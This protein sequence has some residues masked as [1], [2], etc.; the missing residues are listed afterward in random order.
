MEWN[1]DRTTFRGMIWYVLLIVYFT[2]TYYDILNSK[3][4]LPF[5]FKTLEYHMVCGMFLRHVR[6]KVSGDW[7]LS[8]CKAKVFLS[9]L[10]NMHP[11]VIFQNTLNEEGGIKVEDASIFTMRYTD[12]TVLIAENVSSQQNILVWIKE[13]NLGNMDWKWIILHKKEVCRSCHKRPDDRGRRN[14]NGKNQ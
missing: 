6:H 10:F 4:L 9:L 3:S 11:A 12:D 5:L 14:Q 1:N 13:L 2:V 7:Y 8:R